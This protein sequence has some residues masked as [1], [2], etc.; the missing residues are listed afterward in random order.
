MFSFVAHTS[1]MDCVF[2]SDDAIQRPKSGGSA[3]RDPHGFESAGGFC[4]GRRVA[5]KLLRC[6]RCQGDILKSTK[7]VGDPAF[8]LSCSHD[9]ACSRVLTAGA[10]TANGG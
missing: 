1:Q 6:P 4:P 9:V 7:P 5:N 2:R 10:Y 8:S 3:G